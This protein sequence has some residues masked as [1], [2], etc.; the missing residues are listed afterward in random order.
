[1]EVPMFAAVSFAFFM[2]VNGAPAPPAKDVDTLP[3]E[4]AQA[5]A[6]ARQDFEVRYT[7]LGLLGA[8]PLVDREIV[9]VDSSEIASRR[10]EFDGAAQAPAGARNGAAH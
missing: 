2:A 5:L 6:Q 9:A 10:A 8:A 4:L 7:E 3:Q 1:M